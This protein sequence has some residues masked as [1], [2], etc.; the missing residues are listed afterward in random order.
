[1]TD[2]V[3]R[4]LA[5]TRLAE[6]V[7]SAI[8]LVAMAEITRLRA[9]E[10]VFRDEITRLRRAISGSASLGNAALSFATEDAL[11]AKGLWP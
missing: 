3:D 8:A 9:R 2:I 6:P 7:D 5:A 11:K 4:I 10:D 1:M